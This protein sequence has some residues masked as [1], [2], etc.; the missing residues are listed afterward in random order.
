MSSY[1]ILISYLK[2]SL[3]SF[4]TACSP[5]YYGPLCELVCSCNGTDNCNPINGECAENEQCNEDY[6]ASDC[7]EGTFAIFFISVSSQS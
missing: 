1:S 2:L 6:I 7:Q 3:L 4:W 5:G